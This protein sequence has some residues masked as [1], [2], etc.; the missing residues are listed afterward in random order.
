[1]TVV[2]KI[3]NALGT[4]S[5]SQIHITIESGGLDRGGTLTKLM[6]EFPESRIGELKADSYAW[7]NEL[8]TRTIPTILF[9]RDHWPWSPD[10][11]LDDVDYIDGCIK[12]HYFQTPPS[13]KAFNHETVEV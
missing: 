8:K 4:H 9:G 7:L 5:D 3:R 11:C 12:L 1:M 2:E 10:L 6:A 13:R